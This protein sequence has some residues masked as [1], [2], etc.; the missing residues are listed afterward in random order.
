M[1]ALS[2]SVAPR[3]TVIAAF[4]NDIDTLILLMR[5][6]DEQADGSFE[7][8]IADDGSRDDVVQEIARHMA[9]CSYPVRH[10]W[11]ADNGFLKT[12]ILND[13]VR[14]ARGQTLIFVDADC[15]VQTDFVR[16]H[17]VHAGPG[18]MQTGRRVD[19]F[20]DAYQLLDCSHASQIVRRN[21]VRLLLWTLRSKARN[22]EK[23]IRFPIGI[24]RLWRG[25]DWGS[26]V[27]ISRLTVRT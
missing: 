20:H 15:V 14:Q 24:R 22:L 4:Y 1:P 26:W 25:R 27:A 7:L 23:G 3:A 11:Q 21:F 8:I 2:E 13:A 10:I 17:L 9:R 6:L 16:D 19:V 5:A 18:I 12:V